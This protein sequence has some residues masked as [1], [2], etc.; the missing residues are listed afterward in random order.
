MS[1]DR[2]IICINEDGVEV[3]FDYDDESAFFLESVDGVMSVSNKVTTS[4]NTTV[5]GST[6]QGSVTL[7]RN[8]VLTAHI[9]R[10]HV[11]YRNMLYK[12][13]KPKTLGKLTYKEEDE[14]RIIDYRV[15]SVDIDEKGVVRNATI[16][17][18][19]PDPF[20]KDEEDTIV[21]MAGWEARF[22]FPHCFVAE[23][24]PFG[25]RVAEIIKEIENDSAADN[26]GIEILIEAMGAV[27]NPAIYHTEKQ[28]YIKVGT[29]NNPLSLSR[30]EAVRITTGTN[31]KAVYLIQ[32]ETETEINEYLDEGSDFIQL[33]HGRNTF[34]YA[35]D[36]G[37][38]YMNVTITYRLRYLGV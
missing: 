24:E 14:R 5:D 23:K 15:E 16:S 27:T 4:E 9:S 31:E 2:Q 28:E 12:C 20:F 37:R 7:Q 35:A 10:R 33:G 32:G 18:I 11:Y 13:F 17:L 21:T 6:Y 1:A 22:E 38:D 19:C 3:T 8:I 34:T 30:G 25:E 29:E 36:E 26:I